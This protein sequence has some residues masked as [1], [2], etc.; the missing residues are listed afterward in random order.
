MS[1]FATEPPVSVA[2]ALV[3]RAVPVS[4]VPAPGEMSVTLGGVLVVPPVLPL[5]TVICAS[6]L[7]ALACRSRPP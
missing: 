4:V 5:V 1:T 2:V 7:V 3:G 6:P